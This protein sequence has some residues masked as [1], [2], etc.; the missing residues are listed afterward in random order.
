MLIYKGDLTEKEG[1]PKDLIE[2]IESMKVCSPADFTAYDNGSPTHPSF[3]GMHSAGSTCS[4]WLACLYDLTPDQYCE[5]LHVDY[6]VA[7]GRTVAGVHYQQ[8]N[9]AGVNIGQRI[10]REKLPE[11]LENNYGYDSA[12]VA[13]RLKDLSFDWNKFDS[14]DYT[15][16]G[17]SGGDF[18]AEADECAFLHQYQVPNPTDHQILRYSPCLVTR[19]HYSGQ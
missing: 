19:N 7:F 17:K 1:V 16:D 10:I 5:A 12:K 4:L 2:D 14:K 18:L 3:P 15:I 13:K 11:F 8:D 6:A 9:L